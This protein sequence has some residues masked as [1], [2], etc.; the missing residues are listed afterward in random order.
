MSTITRSTSARK[1]STGYP[2]NIVYQRDISLGIGYIAY[3]YLGYTYIQPCFLLRLILP[4]K[5]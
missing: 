1:I 5:Y 3:A 2:W 4:L